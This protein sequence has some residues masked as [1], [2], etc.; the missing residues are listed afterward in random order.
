MKRNL[1]AI[2]PNLTSLPKL[3]IFDCDGVV[4]DSEPLTLQ[5]MCDDLVSR[6]LELS[7]SEMIDLALGGTIAGVGEQAKALGAD[8]PDDWA[9]QFYAKMFTVLG[10][11]VKSIPGIE[12][13]L[14]VLDHH[15]TPYAIGSNGSHKKME[16]TLGRCLLAERFAGRV[17][18]REDVTNPKP[19]PDVYLLAAAKAGIAPRHC[20]VIEDSAAGAR[21]GV[22]AGMAV[23][24]FTH[25][26]PAAKFIGIT[27]V[28]F[29]DMADLPA[30]LGI[31]AE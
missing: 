1:G 23:M 22:A 4:V 7:L 16:I 25:E 29:E 13:V 3:V 9:N 5:L 14:D 17:F 2:M 21:A 6:G 8:I 19:A 30:L 18:S 26:T 10:Q 24:G 12:A 20:V 31:N 11:S 15:G 28:L 27:D